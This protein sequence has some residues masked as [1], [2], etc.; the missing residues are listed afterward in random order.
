MKC[1]YLMAALCCGMLAT[2]CQDEEFGFTTEDVFR[3]AYARNFEQKIGAVDP[4]QSWDFSSY[5]RAH[6]EALTRAY[7]EYETVASE[8][9][10]YHVENATL[11]WMKGQLPESNNNKVKTKPFSFAWSKGSVFEIIPIYQGKAGMTWELHMVLGSEDKTI[12]TKAQGMEQKKTCTTCRGTGKNSRG[13]VCS[14]CNGKGET[15]WTKLSTDGLSENGQTLDATA[16]RSKTIKTE[17][18]FKGDYEDGTPLSF[19]LKITYGINNWAKTGTKQSSEKGM[20][21]LLDCPSPTNISATYSSYLLGCEDADLSSSDWDFNDVVFLMT[22]YIPPV[23]YEDGKN[24]KTIAKRYLVEDLT[25]SGDFDFNDIVVDV[26]QTTTTWY[27]KN[28]E[29]GAYEIH[30]DHPT[31]EVEQQATI[32]WMGG[33]VPIQVQVGDYTFGRVSAPTQ[34][35]QTAR[36]LLGLPVGRWADNLWDMNDGYEPLFEGEPITCPITGWDP[37]R[38]N[39][40]VKV[41]WNGEEITDEGSE[42][43]WKNTFPER[44][45]IPFMVATDIYETPTNWTEEGE[46]IDQTSWWKENYIATQK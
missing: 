29:T 20:I 18:F 34:Q 12:W 24:V 41:W 38:N 5:G 21:C 28:T 33:T 15:D 17:D 39:I 30:P 8:D 19:Y 40:T 10:Y 31:P 43:T 36:E 7:A 3:G 44:G 9:G 46:D 25:N 14:A 4:N 45:T 37:D 27:R 32:R 13:G 42:Q 35:E 6:N 16:I 2:S 26:K 23:I 11:D 22:G 1:R